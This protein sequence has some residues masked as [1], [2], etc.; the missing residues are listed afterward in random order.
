MKDVAYSVFKYKGIGILFLALVPPVA[1][2]SIA[3]SL[4]INIRFDFKQ[5]VGWKEVAD[6]KKKPV[7]SER[8]G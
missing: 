8:H 5:C 2:L 1:S 4:S 7:Y 3:L 6:L